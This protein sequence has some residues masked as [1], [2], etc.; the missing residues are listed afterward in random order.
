MWWVTF[1]WIFERC[2]RLGLCH[3]CYD[4]THAHLFLC[5]QKIVQV[6]PTP[7]ISVTSSA[8]VKMGAGRDFTVLPLSA[9]TS[10]AP[11]IGMLWAL[12]TIV[13]SSQSFFVSELGV[14]SH[15]LWPHSTNTSILAHRHCST[16]VETK[17][18]LLQAFSSKRLLSF[19]RTR[20]HRFTWTCSIRTLWDQTI[21]P[22]SARI[23]VTPWIAVVTWIPIYWKK[24]N[25]KILPGWV[26]QYNINEI[27]IP[28]IVVISSR[29]KF[30]S[31]GII[32]AVFPFHATGAFWK[33]KLKEKY[34]CT[35][36][37]SIVSNCVW[38][39]LT[40][41]HQLCRGTSTLSHLLNIP[42]PLR[43][44]QRL[45]LKSQKGQWLEL[46]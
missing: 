5:P 37:L 35:K 45:K 13:V 46:E 31:R 44:Q 27:L 33:K 21:L 18:A 1:V 7:E 28:A 6:H 19:C 4:R 32:F 11:G 25:R 23:F 10:P 15:C 40:L 9:S 24:K 22:T 43:W 39:H 34:F 3:G 20:R 36:F 17:L 14:D 2:T 12:A 26:D 29:S 41:S 30:F 38:D 16:I 8:L 42:S